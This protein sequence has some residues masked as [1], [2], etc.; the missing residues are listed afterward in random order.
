MLKL[1]TKWFKKWSK[2]NAVKDDQLHK[3]LDSI[4]KNAGIVDLGGGLYKV[5]IPGEQ[6]G[7]SGGFRS[8][9]VYRDFDLAI[10]VFGFSKNEKENL[11][12]DELKYF[13]K[14][15]KDLLKF[16]KQKYIKLIQSGE[17]YY[18]EE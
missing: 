16:D 5:R 11:S 8:I 15:A 12:K 9:V 2:K 14:L 13:K 18:L 6:K 3:A 1:K 4:S 7:K 10:F 17:F